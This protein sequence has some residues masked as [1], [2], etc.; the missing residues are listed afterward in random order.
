MRWSSFGLSLIP[1]IDLAE[2][3]Q[4]DALPTVNLSK[5]ENAKKRFFVHAPPEVWLLFSIEAEVVL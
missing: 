3:L 2:L 5:E 4:L 1:L